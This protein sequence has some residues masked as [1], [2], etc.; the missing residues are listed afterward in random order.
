MLEDA[1]ALQKKTRVALEASEG[2]EEDEDS[3]ASA[4]V[5]PKLLL[6]QLTLCRKDPER[7]MKFAFVDAKDKVPAM[8]ALHPRMSARAVQQAP[9][10]LRRE[11][12]RLWN[13]LD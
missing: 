7:S 1:E 9:G 11:D 10:G 12:R 3:A 5:N 8:L 4:L 6:K 13:G 2:E